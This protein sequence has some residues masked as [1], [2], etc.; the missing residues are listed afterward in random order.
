MSGP[1]PRSTVRFGVFEVDLASGELRKSGVKIK[2][3]D[4]PFRFLAVL[5]ERPGEVVTRE[6]LR[7]TLWPD[8]VYVDFDRS[9][10]AAVS[11]IRDALSDSAES[12]RFIETLPRRGYRFV[13][14]VES[15]SNGPP[16]PDAPPKGDAP[17]ADSGRKR[18]RVYG[19]AAAGVLALLVIVLVASGIFPSR[20][21]EGA[22]PP[23]ASDIP[24]TKPKVV[25]LPFA[26]LNQDADSDY[27]S[28]G[29]T[30]AVIT[31]LGTVS[32]LWVIS[33]T[34]S[35]AYQGAKKPLSEIAAE[36]KVSHVV[37]GAVLRVKD[38]VRITVQLVDARHDRQVWSKKYERPLEE[39]LALQSAVAA[40]IARGVEVELTPREEGYFAA[41]P[42][43]NRE[44]QEAY[45]RG[46]HEFIKTTFVRATKGTEADWGK[47]IAYFQEAIEKEPLHAWAHAALADMLRMTGMTGGRAGQDA[48]L[49]AKQAAEKAVKLGPDLAEAHAVLGAIRAQFDRDWEGAEKELQEAIRLNPSSIAARTESSIYFVAVGR[50]DEALREIRR[51]QE[52]DPMSPFNHELEAWVHYM[53]GD[54][55]AAVDKCLRTLKMGPDEWW[56]YNVL[57]TAYAERGSHDEAAAALQRALRL[58]GPEAGGKAQLGYA[59]GLAGNRAAAL[60][61]LDE[62]DELAKS[63]YVPP[64]FLAWTH[65]GLGNDARVFDLLEQAYRERVPNMFALRVER[66]FLQYHSHPR[67]QALVKKMNFPPVTQP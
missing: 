15:E 29:L 57:G 21:R 26:N 16:A 60:K 12:P 35:M 36:L 66:P 25:V 58:G 24:D 10:N 61:I 39:I 11:R 41:R 27:L 67:F 45:L 3:Q 13:A 65:A 2:V 18:A 52:L 55:D 38:R 43:I 20:D 42:E 63:E 47:A 6:Q 54:Y 33:R 14:P 62:L 40:D 9:L 51:A 37:D 46:Q 44:A 48:M 22:V 8:G 64:Y 34:S 32:A 30:D 23:P 28:D 17:A 7:E 59:Y 19:L 5:L 56:T 50:T 53:A 31:D 1:Q 49:R 4:L